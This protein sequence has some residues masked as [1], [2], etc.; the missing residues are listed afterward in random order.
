MGSP[1]VAINSIEPTSA[2][3]LSLSNFV[4]SYPTE[5]QKFWED[6]RPPTGDRI[7]SLRDWESCCTTTERVA[8]S[9]ISE[10]LVTLLVQPRVQES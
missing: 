7:P 10:A 5:L 2:G 1:S 9:D 4:H 3:I 8:G 6:G